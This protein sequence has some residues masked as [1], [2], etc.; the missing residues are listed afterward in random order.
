MNT[1]FSSVRI[2]IKVWNGAVWDGE[3]LFA[4]GNDPWFA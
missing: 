3:S 1:N 2:W 4:G